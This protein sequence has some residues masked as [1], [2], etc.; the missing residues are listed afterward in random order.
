[1]K[2]KIYPAIF[3]MA[4]E[5]GYWV[6]FPDLDGCI[7]EGKTLEEASIMAKEALELYIDGM[8]DLPKPTKIQNIKVEKGAVVMLVGADNTG[9]I[10]HF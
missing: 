6:S 10:I 2:N 4:E 5:G 3:H 8:K 1:M 7:T 9:G